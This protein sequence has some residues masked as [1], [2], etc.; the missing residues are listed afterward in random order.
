[1]NTDYTKLA[2]KQSLE[3]T[4]AALK[5]KNYNPIVVKTKDEALNKIKELIPAGA[6]VTNGSSITLNQIGYQDYLESKKHSWRDLNSEIR[7]EG[8]D[9]KRQELRKEATLSEYYLGSV[10]A[11]TETG[12]MIIA[13]NTGSQLPHLVYTSPNLILVVSTKKI[14]ADIDHALKRL[15]E[16]VVPLENDRMMKAM[17]APTTLNKILIFKGDAAYLGRKINIILIEEDLGF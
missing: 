15:E 2:S 16:H 3:K 1:M 6:T 10:H 13:S 7:A 9:A 11:M 12:E 8:D 5:E 17:G 4:V 14:V